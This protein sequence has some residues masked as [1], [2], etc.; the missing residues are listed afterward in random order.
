MS[1]R[2]G[3]LRTRRA[4]AWR[5]IEDHVQSYDV[6]RIIYGAIIGL[7]L[8]LALQVHPPSAAQIAGLVVATAIAIGL[9]ELYSDIVGNQARDRR[10]VSPERAHALAAQ[11]AAA[12][13]GAAFPALF[14]VLAAG[15]AISLALAFTLAKWSG[16]GLIC[17]YGFIASRLA[18]SGTGRALVHAALGGA[19]AGALIAFKALLH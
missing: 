13:L 15:H 18:G 7:A 6:A 1:A 11:A 10:P 4:R 17:G 3:R 19:V 12:T 2:A 5:Q 8:V 16:L 14:F 9:A